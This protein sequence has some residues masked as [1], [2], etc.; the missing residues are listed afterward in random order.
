MLASMVWFSPGGIA[1][2]ELGVVVL[3]VLAVCGL[4]YWKRQKILDFIDW[5][6]RD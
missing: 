6:D 1:V 3:V 4:V 2:F 5:Q